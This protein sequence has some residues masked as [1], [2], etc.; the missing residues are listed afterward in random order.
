MYTTG[1]STLPKEEQN[2][3][4]NLKSLSAQIYYLPSVSTVL[5]AWYIV[6]V[7]LLIVACSP[8]C[9]LAFGENG[10]SK[11]RHK[12]GRSRVCLILHALSD[13][14]IIIVILC[15]SAALQLRSASCLH[16]M[17]IIYIF[18]IT[19]TSLTGNI[20]N[21]CALSLTRNVP[22]IQG[23]SGMSSTRYPAVSISRFSLF[24]PFASW[25]K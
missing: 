20:I 10:I 17:H 2:H 1:A 14:C 24:V 15:R 6:I 21:I 18:G 13:P 25:Q 22:Y 3:H 11:I 7:S 12:T 9:L 23:Q 16:V 5:P 19:G 4:R 8:S